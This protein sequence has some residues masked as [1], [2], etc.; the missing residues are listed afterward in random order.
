M[1]QI[2]DEVDIARK[3]LYNHFPVKEAIIAT[4]VQR[5]LKEQWTE[6]IQYVQGLPDTRSRLTAVLLKHWEWAE[7]ELTRDILGIY[8]V[9]RMQTLLQSFKDRNL[10]TGFADLLAYI[11]RLRQ[12]VRG[13]QAGYI[14]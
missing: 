5:A 3:T 8:H 6:M 4:Y 2:A 11:I 7:I 9:Y 12:G 13:D 1:E 14:G 10:R